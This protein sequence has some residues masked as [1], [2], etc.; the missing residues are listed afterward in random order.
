M[1]EGGRTAGKV[2]GA[3]GGGEAGV[4]GDEVGV[5]GELA[6]ELG[7]TEEE[8]AGRAGAEMAGGAEA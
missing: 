1:G 4:G 6:V 3:A 5:T 7:T 8:G 2:E